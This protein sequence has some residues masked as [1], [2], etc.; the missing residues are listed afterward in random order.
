M[1][2]SVKFGERD[3]RTGIMTRYNDVTGTGNPPGFS[4]TFPDPEIRAGYDI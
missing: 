3:G 1:F 4:E 2:L